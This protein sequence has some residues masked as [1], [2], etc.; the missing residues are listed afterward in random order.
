MR[1]SDWRSDVC[2]SDLATFLV[3]NALDQR[4]TGQEVGG[5]G[6]ENDFHP[7]SVA[8]PCAIDASRIRP[9]ASAGIPWRPALASAELQYLAGPVERREVRNAPVVDRVD[10]EAQRLRRLVGAWCNAG[11]SGQ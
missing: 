3:Q 5:D 11:P 1:I 6:N 2:S 4:G 10:H 9:P 8:Y 7:F